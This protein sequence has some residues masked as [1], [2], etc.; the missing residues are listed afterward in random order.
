MSHFTFIASR[1]GKKS[2]NTWIARKSTISWNLTKRSSIS[3]KLW[4]IKYTIRLIIIVIIFDIKLEKKNTIASSTSSFKNVKSRAHSMREFI[5]I[6]W[7]NNTARYR[8]DCNPTIRAIVPENPKNFPRIKSCLL[9]GFESMRKIVFP[10]ISLN[11]N[12]LPTK[13]TQISPKISIIPRPKSTTTLSDSPIVSFHSARE[14][15]I[16]TKAKNRIRYKNLFLTI[17]LK[18]LREFKLY[19]TVLYLTSIFIWCKIFMFT[20]DRGLEWNFNASSMW[21][22]DGNW[23]SNSTCYCCSKAQ[24][25]K[26][27]AF[28]CCSLFASCC[29]CYPF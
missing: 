16:N 18:F 17:S 14:N 13:S 8:R 6:H 7:K 26:G 19:K 1:G 29:A 10:S 15:R 4:D 21:T 28:L 12:W 24:K 11:S 22:I 23:N 25:W 20:D 27:R 2:W 3:E 5:S 9:I